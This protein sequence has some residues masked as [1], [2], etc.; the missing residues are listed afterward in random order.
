MSGANVKHDLI[1]VDR[2]AD[3]GER[4]GDAH[5]AAEGIRLAEGAE[6]AKEAPQY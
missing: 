1:E 3:H 6:S 4:E 2:G 5:E